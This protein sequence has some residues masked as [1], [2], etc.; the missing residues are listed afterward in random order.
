MLLNYHFQSLFA[1]NKG[2]CIIN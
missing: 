2:A 1:K